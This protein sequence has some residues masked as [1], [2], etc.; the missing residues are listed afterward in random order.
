MQ[1]ATKP[2]NE[3]DELAQAELAVERSKRELTRRLYLARRSGER[4]VHSYGAK[5]VPIAVLTVVAVGATVAVTAALR[6]RRRAGRWSS[7][8]NSGSSVAPALKAVGLWALRLAV[9]RVVVPWLVR[10]LV[11][12]EAPAPTQAQ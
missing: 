2:S 12:E 6:Q 3:T 8:G 9:R 10:T 5:L 4:L 11:V 7:P 1:V